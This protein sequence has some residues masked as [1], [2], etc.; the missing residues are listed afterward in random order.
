[1]FQGV[2]RTE[3]QNMQ[4]SVTPKQAKLLAFI[5]EYMAT[6]EGIAPSYAEMMAATGDASKAGIH[7]LL[8]GL[9]ERGHIAQMKNR[10]RSIVLLEAG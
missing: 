6:S 5:K 2:K 8:T 3:R 10:A 4:F 9:A 1:M 7:R